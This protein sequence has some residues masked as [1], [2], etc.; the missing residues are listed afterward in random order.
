MRYISLAF[1]G[2]AGCALGPGD[3]F[4]VVEPTFV[5]G[6]EVPNGRDAG[7][8]WQRLNTDYQATF[9]RLDLTLT[10][11]TL[12]DLGSSGPITFDPASPPPGYT[13]CHNGHCDREDGALVPYEDMQAELNQGGGGPRTVVTLP[14][15]NVDAVAGT[16]RALACEPSCDL[17]LA[18]I[19]RVRGSL[20]RV[21]F[22]GLVRDSRV[23]AR[24]SGD[25]PW[26]LTTELTQ[27]LSPTGALELAANNENPLRA[28][29]AFTFALSGRLLDDV[30]WA[31]AD[32]TGG[33]IDLA[34]AANEA[35]RTVVLENL[36]TTP[37][38][39]EVTR[40]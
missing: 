39:A 21:S 16:S 15:G 35:H 14:V 18:D 6:L 7:D 33:P 37:I 36:A 13:I 1:F 31:V 17:P 2:L 12:Q 34:S 32:A 28:L 26:S 38:S 29:V 8:G 9:T 25:V 19:S 20:V 23:P 3:P 10:N 40:R 30:D 5:S 4:A 22:A 24:I 27:P 11:L